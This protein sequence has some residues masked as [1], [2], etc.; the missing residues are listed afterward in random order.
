[1][2]DGCNGVCAPLQ[3]LDQLGILCGCCQRLEIETITQD[4]DASPVLAAI[5]FFPSGFQPV[6]NLLVDM[7]GRGQNASW[8][9]TVLKE[10]CRVLKDGKAVG[11][12]QACRENWRETNQGMK[13][14]I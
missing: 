1:M 13:Q 3:L 6:R 7:A 14:T 12:G 4:G 8:L 10:R 9:R 5:S 11:G 2:E